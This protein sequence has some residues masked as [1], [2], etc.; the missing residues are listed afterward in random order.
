MDTRM[1]RSSIRRRL[2]PTTTTVNIQPLI[3]TF[4]YAYIIFMFS[5]IFKDHSIRL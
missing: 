3:V 2:R 5:F 4:I 1:R